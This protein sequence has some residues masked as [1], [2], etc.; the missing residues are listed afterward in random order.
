MVLPAPGPSANKLGKSRGFARVPWVFRFLI[1][2][3]LSY[4]EACVYYQVALHCDP[5]EEYR[6]GLDQL[7]ERMGWKRTN[8][9]YACLNKLVDTGFLIKRRIRL[10][11]PRKY[12]VNV[13]QRPTVGYTLRRLQSAGYVGRGKRIRLEQFEEAYNLYQTKDAPHEPVAFQFVK[14][15]KKEVTIP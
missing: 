10:T 8:A 5:Q 13:Y 7:A 4:R 15:S 6:F 1:N 11:G 14:A 9:L 12:W 2:R 3:V